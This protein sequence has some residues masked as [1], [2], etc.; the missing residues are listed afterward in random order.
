MT[1]DE[2]GKRRNPGCIVYMNHLFKAREPNSGVETI[3]SRSRGLCMLL[4]G[5]RLGSAGTSICHPQADLK[6]EI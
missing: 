5:I 3:P 6:K 1:V 4:R 2:D